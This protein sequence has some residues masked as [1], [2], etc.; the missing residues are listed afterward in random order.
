MATGTTKKIMR[1]R[2]IITG[3][4]GTIGMALIRKCIEDDVEA[5]VLAN[6]DSS[7]LSRLPDDPHVKVIKCGLSDLADADGDCLGL[8]KISGS[9][10]YADAMFH[11]AWG[12]TFGDA[13]NNR[14]LQQ[15]N[16][17]YAEGAAKLAGRLGC[18]VFVGAGS[19]AEYGRVSG[20]ISASTPCAPENEYG[21]AKLEAGIATRRLCAQL[22]IRHIWPRILSIY[23]PYDG[24]KTMIMSLISSLLEGAVPPLTKGEQMWDYLFADDAADALML[25]ARKGRDGCIYPIGSGVARPLREY[26]ETIRDVIDPQLKLGFGQVPYSDKQVMHLCADISELTAHTGFVPHVSFEEGAKRTVDFVRNNSR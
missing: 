20:V 8:E 26:I 11:L 16:A 17:K 7:R 21:R 5:V 12:G 10:R 25:L 22:S 9:G 14:G 3:A 13:R 1:M 6:P 18:D 15:Q 24:E 23:G 2:V 4:T 19:Q